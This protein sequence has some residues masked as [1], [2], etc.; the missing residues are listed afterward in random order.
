L[1][2]L[3]L[4]L[5]AIYLVR[6]LPAIVYAR[7]PGRARSLIAGLLQ[8]TSLTFI[9]TA[10][11]IGLQLGVVSHASAAALIAAGLLS[12]VISPALR[13][14]L[15]RRAQPRT[16]AQADMRSPAMPLLTAEDRALCGVD[17]APSA[18]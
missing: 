8:A 17:A 6:G 7:L 9:V 16:V 18:A 2:G 15:L 11:Q 13:L 5:L 3:P 4:F 1:R 12:V 14:A 10:T